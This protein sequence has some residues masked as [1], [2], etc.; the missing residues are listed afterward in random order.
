[1]ASQADIDK[2]IREIRSKLESPEVRNGLFGNMLKSVHVQAVRGMT[3]NLEFSWPVTALAGANGSGKT[4]LLQLCSAAY[5]KPEGGRNYKIGDWIRNALAGETPAFR[6]GSGVNFS[7]WND[8]PR[9]LI[10]YRKDRTRWD[11][12]RRNNPERPVQFFGITTFAPR[13]ERKDRLHVFRSQI[14]I[15]KS[16]PIDDDMLASISR[17]LG[18]TYSGGTMHTVGLAKGDWSEVLPQVTRGETIYAE[19]HMG[20]GEQKVVRLVRALEALP[21]RSL[22]LLEEPEITLH[23][24]AQRGLA[25][26]LMNLARRKGHQI[27]LTT[28]SAEIFETLPDEARALIIRR[29]GGVD[30]VPRPPHIAAARELAGV[31]KTNKDLIL[32]ED[33][34]AREFL[35]DILRRYDRVLLE[36]ACIAPVGNTDDVYRLVKSFRDEGVRAV[37]IRDP[38]IGPDAANHVFSLPGDMAPETLLL[39]GGNIAAA[40]QIINGIADAFERAKVAGV[41]R[42]GS[43]WAKAVFPALAH[44]MRITEAMLRDRLTMA[45]LNN[46]GE[47]AEQLVARVK[48]VLV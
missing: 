37:G 29:K 31:V 41:G 39:D 10:P 2:E 26:Y 27:I 11:Y 35:T 46:N 23:P 1:M 45:W 8:A 20:A 40:E 38:D 22:V 17:V 43:K 36:N 7:F 44:E 6:E 25:W 34:V 3:V 33:S 16:A 42:E 18:V 4:T 47:E 32:V 15:K 12:P 21:Q 48:Q 24:D 14:E 9:V 13:I 19:P 28:H 30:V 5:V